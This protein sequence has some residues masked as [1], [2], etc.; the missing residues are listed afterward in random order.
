MVHGLALDG[1]RAFLGDFEAA[2]DLI[3]GFRSDDVALPED[4]GEGD[5]DDRQ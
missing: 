2:S 4:P 1:S 5:S 3:P